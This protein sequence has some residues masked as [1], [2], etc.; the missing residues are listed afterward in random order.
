[1][2]RFLIVVCALLTL[3]AE[4]LDRI[5][6]VV[7]RQ[8]ITELQLDEELRVTA[9]LNGQPIARDL[10]ARRAAA[11]R[12][13]EQVLV[14]REIEVSHYPLPETGDVDKFE[15]QVRTA[16]SRSADF[17]TE[18]RKYGLTDE[19]LR[20]HLQLQLTILQFVELRFRP[21][22]GISSEEIETYYQSHLMEWKAEHP[23]A[24]PPTLADSRE[25]IRKALA[26][27]RTDEALDTWLETSRKQVSI[28]Y[29]DKSLS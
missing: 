20:E 19:T 2:Y 18:L 13:I 25:S 22:L 14:K 9:F 5:A 1:M 17:E 23:G 28:T 15:Q 4:V 24:R 7:G 11:G 27:R 16:T 8:V 6:I 29:L 3:R 12:L 26:E 10:A 21:D